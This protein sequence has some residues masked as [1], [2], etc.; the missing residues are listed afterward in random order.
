MKGVTGGGLPARLFREIM[1]AAHRGLEPKAL[2]GRRSLG[3]FWSLLFGGGEK[4][5][6]PANNAPNAPNAPN[7]AG[8]SGRATTGEGARPGSSRRWVI[9][10]DDSGPE[11][12]N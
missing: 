9:Q 5:A 3:G 4:P 7:T 6:T 1:T 10:P 2:P 11:Y 12:P 8:G